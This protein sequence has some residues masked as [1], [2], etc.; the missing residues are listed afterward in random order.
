MARGNKNNNKSTEITNVSFGMNAICLEILKKIEEHNV[1][2]D[3][4]ID[5]SFVDEVPNIL[6]NVCY[7][8]KIETVIS[9]KLKANPKDA[10]ALDLKETRDK[11]ILNLPIVKNIF[12]MKDL[13]P[14]GYTLK[15]KEI[16][17][18]NDKKYAKTGFLPHQLRGFYNPVT[19]TEENMPSSVIAFNFSK[20]GEIET[21][22][23]LFEA[24]LISVAYNQYTKRYGI[25]KWKIIYATEKAKI[26]VV[27]NVETFEDE[28]FQ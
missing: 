21:G 27:K 26:D 12:Q 3:T 25:Y 22:E 11:E 5:D 17:K 4:G 1:I 13:V 9:A 6:V 14:E 20:V 15:A 19:I 10:T 2:I 18:K 7:N 16:S 24:K 28:L 8:P 23:T